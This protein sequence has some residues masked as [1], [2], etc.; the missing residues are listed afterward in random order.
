MKNIDIVINCSGLNSFWESEKSKYYEINT[1]EVQNIMES[2]LESNVK[3]IVPISAVMVYGFPKETPFTEESIPG[4]HKS[5][6]ARSKYL[7][8][9]IARELYK[10][11]NLPLVIGY[12]AA[13]IGAENN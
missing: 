10:I 3:K 8:D 13:V 11:N 2:A 7:G 4:S 1:K 12:L 9:K 5:E 6:Y